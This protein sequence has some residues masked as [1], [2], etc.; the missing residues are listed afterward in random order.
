M[1][2]TNRGAE[3]L[4]ADN[5][6]T[7]AWVVRRLLDGFPELPAGDWIEP[8]VGEGAVVRAV[9]ATRKDMRVVH[10]MDVRDVKKAAVAAGC[11]HFRIGDASD[12]GTHNGIYRSTSA[13]KVAPVGAITNPPYSKAFA[14]AKVLVAR[15]SYVALLLRLNFLGSGTRDGRSDWLRAHPPD[16]GV[17]PNRPNF[18][19][20]IKCSS[21]IFRAFAAIQDKDWPRACP[22]CGAKTTRTTSDAS[23]YGWF[24][25]KPGER[26]RGEIFVLGDTSEAERNATS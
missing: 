25:W 9:H 8:C 26:R 24:V 16:V 17:L 12:F 1:S 2:A 21:C 14:I 20:S 5:Y 11:D 15:Y 19:A 3:R 13:G 7:P 4:D 22:A 18:V 10:G 23:E 6:P